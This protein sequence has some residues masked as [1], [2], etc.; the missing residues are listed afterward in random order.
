MFVF[1]CGLLS[2]QLSKQDGLLLLLFSKSWSFHVSFFAYYIGIRASFLLH[3]CSLKI[4]KL[5]QK[6]KNFKKQ[7][8]TCI[9][10]SCVLFNIELE[11]KWH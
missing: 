4:N 11:K 6:T 1:S 9:R 3:F 2:S 7:K 5:Y 8:F 10:V